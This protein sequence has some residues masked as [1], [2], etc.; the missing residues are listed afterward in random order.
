M[1][2]GLHLIVEEYILKFLWIKAYDVKKKKNIRCLE[3][4]LKS[5]LGGTWGAQLVV[6]LQLRS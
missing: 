3:C 2:L 1:V 4:A 6:G 5:Y